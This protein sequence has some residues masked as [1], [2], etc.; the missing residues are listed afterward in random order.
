MFSS[1]PRS[2]SR[3]SYRFHLAH[4]TYSGWTGEQEAKETLYVSQPERHQVRFEKTNF[5]HFYLKYEFILFE[6]EI[7]HRHRISHIVHSIISLQFV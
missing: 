3:V 7:L 4:S 6:F 2:S 1:P 5:E